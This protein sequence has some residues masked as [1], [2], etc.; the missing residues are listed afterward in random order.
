MMNLP[1]NGDEISCRF[2]ARVCLIVSF[3]TRLF[4]AD[5]TFSVGN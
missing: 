4:A 2:C 5:G 3:V 1:G